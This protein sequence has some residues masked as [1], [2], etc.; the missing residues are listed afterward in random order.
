[1]HA[2]PKM[3]EKASL[4]NYTSIASRERLK[5]VHHVLL[6]EPRRDGMISQPANP[7]SRVV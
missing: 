3:L 2:M 7:M 6:S 1:M 5:I 4:L